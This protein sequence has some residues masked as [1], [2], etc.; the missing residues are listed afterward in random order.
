MLTIEFSASFDNIGAVIAEIY[1]PLPEPDTIVVE[2]PS[3]EGIEIMRAK[4]AEYSED[5]PNQFL[6]DITCLDRM[7][8][9]L[10]FL[11]HYLQILALM[12]L[13]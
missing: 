5:F 10:K 11:V 3:M 2:I 1:I 4:F 7:Q 9:N 12:D 8:A 6:F 13:L